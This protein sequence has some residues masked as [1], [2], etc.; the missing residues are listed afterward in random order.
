MNRENTAQKFILEVG[1]IFIIMIM[2]VSML[3]VNANAASKSG[4]DYHVFTATVPN[5]GIVVSWGI[6]FNTTINYTKGTGAY[7]ATGVST[8]AII[9]P[10]NNMGNGKLAASMLETKDYGSTVTRR[11]APVCDSFWS[12]QDTIKPTNSYLYF[13]KKGTLNKSFSYEFE[14]KGSYSFSY[15]GGIVHS[16]NHKFP[17][18]VSGPK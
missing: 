10:S 6:T 13:A 3:T 11:I 2:L 14:E 17:F 8:S 12:N 7:K 9:S 5:G 18:A 16:P 15:S 1:C 4:S